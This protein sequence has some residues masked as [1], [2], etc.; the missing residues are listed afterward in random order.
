VITASVTDAAGVETSADVTLIVTT[1]PIVTITAPPD[2]QTVTAGEPL[3][4][5]ATADDAEDGDLSAGVTWTSSRDGLLGTGPSI[6]RSDLSV[7]IHVLTA[8]AADSH[9]IGASAEITLVV[10]APPRVDIVAPPD[11]TS[12]TERDAVTLIGTAV[13]VEDGDLS[14]S[15]QWVSSLDGAIGTG[16]SITRSDL[17]IGTHTITA[18]AADGVGIGDS[19]QIVLTVNPNVAPTVTITS[20]PDGTSLP[21]ASAT[22]TGTALDPE[23]G[24]IS[25]RLVWSTSKDGVIGT[26]ASITR[27]D[28]S[29]GAQTVTASVTDDK[30]AVASASITVKIKKR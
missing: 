25:D 23:D 17:S 16:A 21:R 13:D 29:L 26:G 8:S 2:G 4:L 12:V 11:G 3:T 20:P 9:G 22:F 14:A 1:T 18:S 7:G 27:S 19:D 6:T 5:T 24:D 10:N 30:D 28:L 15:I